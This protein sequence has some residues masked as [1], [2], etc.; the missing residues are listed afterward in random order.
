MPKPVKKAVTKRPS[1]DP[2][3]RARQMLTEHMRKLS[4]GKFAEPDA[5]D[6]KAII[7]AHMAALGAKG[8]KVSGAKRMEMPAKQRREIALNAAKARW[9]KKR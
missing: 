2:M 8:G 6:A 1:S 4:E 5:P 3:T 7:S 9:A